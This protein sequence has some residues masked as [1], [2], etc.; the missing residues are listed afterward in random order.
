MGVW[1]VSSL[2]QWRGG[3]RGVAICYDLEFLL[4]GGEV[5]AAFDDGKHDL[6]RLWSAHW[7][8][9]M[10]AFL[11]GTQQPNLTMSTSM[12][13][14]TT[15]AGPNVPMDLFTRRKMPRNSVVS[16]SSYICVRI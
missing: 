8:F 12:Y 16:S 15:C 6:N 2:G 10:V 9:G 11:C 3:V 13:A 7:T 4:E 5:G 1:T 14:W